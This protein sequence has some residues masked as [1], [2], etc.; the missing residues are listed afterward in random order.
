MCLL[1]STGDGISLNNFLIRPAKILAMSLR[2]LFEGYFYKKIMFCI[3]LSIYKSQK[4]LDPE[5]HNE[6]N[7]SDM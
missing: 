5:I 6:L 2:K 7:G 4:N 1:L 3:K